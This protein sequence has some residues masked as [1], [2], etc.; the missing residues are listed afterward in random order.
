MGTS[1]DGRKPFWLL[2]FDIVLVPPENCS[3][4]TT[5]GQMGAVAPGRGKRGGAK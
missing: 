4:V 5:G 2:A 3:G 1:I